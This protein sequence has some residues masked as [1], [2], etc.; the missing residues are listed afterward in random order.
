[1]KTNYLLEKKVRD[2]LALARLSQFRHLHLNKGESVKNINK[3]KEYLLCFVLEGTVCLIKNKYEPSPTIVTSNEMF[4]ITTLEEC[5]LKAMEDCNIIIHTC[6]IIAPYFHDRLLN[7]L[8]GIDLDKVKTSN[9]LSIHDL[10]RSFLDLLVDYIN[11]DCKIMELHT[12]KE[13]ELFVLFKLCH[14]KMEI[15]SFFHKALSQNLNFFVTVMNHYK[16]CRTAKELAIKC[17]YNEITFSRLFKECFQES[18]YSWLKRQT[19][20][21]IKKKLQEGNIPIKQIIFEYNFKTF[22]HFTTFCHRNL[23]GA[24]NTIRKASDK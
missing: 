14:T 7:Y 19:S 6:N 15:A 9:T 16:S 13:T 1:M 20:E 24:P 22:S 18:A 8:D 5:Y 23:G 11:E 4:F 2:P 12:A 17:N 10:M 21:E 3:D